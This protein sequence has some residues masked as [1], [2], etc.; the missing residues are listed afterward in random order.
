MDSFS[1]NIRSLNQLQNR[2]SHPGRAPRREG[3]GGEGA[4][5]GAGPVPATAGKHQPLKYS[6][7]QA[8]DSFRAKKKFFFKESIISTK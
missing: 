5:L 1:G 8:S 6:P 3:E 2:R 4:P 7:S